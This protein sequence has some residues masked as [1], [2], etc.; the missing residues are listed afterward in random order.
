[1]EN[2][3][4]IEE[5]L[6]IVR[7]ERELNNKRFNQLSSTMIDLSKEVKGVKGEL[8]EIRKEMDKVYVSL[9]E[10]IQAL[11]SDMGKT[12]KRVDRLQKKLA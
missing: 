5:I 3:Q 1:M 6:G 7:D 2:D 11:A 9:S 10:D 8:V 12:D 4:K